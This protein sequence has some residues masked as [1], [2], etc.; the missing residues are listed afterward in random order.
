M[1]CQ[2]DSIEMLLFIDLGQSLVFHRKVTKPGIICPLLPSCG[3]KSVLQAAHVSH[4]NMSS[5]LQAKS[6][7]KIE[8]TP[9]H[10][11]SITNKTISTYQ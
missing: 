11:Q 9:H 5:S 2:F 6:P 4:K 1:Y 3:T 8:N 7:T 10:T